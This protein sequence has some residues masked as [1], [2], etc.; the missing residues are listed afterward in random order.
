MT[1][2]RLATQGS[3]RSTV[4]ATRSEMALAW[5]SPPVRRGVFGS[6]LLLTGALSPAYLPEASPLRSLTGGLLGH[7]VVQTAA[8]SLMLV[9]VVILF[10]AWLR[11]RPVGGVT[12]PTSARATLAWWCLPLLV[13][14]PLFSSD[15]FSYAAQG[16]LVADGID[17]YQYGPFL[18]PD[19]FK[20]LVDPLW[21]Y[22]PAP[23]GPLS[24]QVNRFIVELTGRDAWWSAVLIRLPAILG[25]V[26]LLWAVRRLAETFGVDG[27][28]AIWWGVLNPI[29]LMHFV[30]GSHNDSLMV[31]IGAVALV[32]ATEGFLLGSA[33]VLGVAALMKQPIAFMLPACIALALAHRNGTPRPAFRQVVRGSLLAGG[34]FL[35]TFAAGT[36]ISGLGFG[37]ISAAGVPGSV[38][39]LSPS[40]NI[41]RILEWVLS[42]VHAPAGAL[43]M[44]MPLARTAV[45]AFGL[46]LGAFLALRCLH[47]ASR[48]AQYIC[49]GMIAV[50]SCLPALQ[51]W[52]LLWGG[53]FIG[54]VRLSERQERVVMIM[55]VALL[56]YSTID[57]VFRTGLLSFVI[58]AVMAMAFP[59]ITRRSTEHALPAFTPTVTRAWQA[60]VHRRSHHHSP[61]D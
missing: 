2:D 54:L 26:L 53:V 24:L 9:G 19:N 11:L 51:V 3:V 20:E 47:D 33:S 43:T 23:Y 17:P 14:P 38:G 58:L 40:T 35:G 37:W 5:S 7:W 29:V 49:W 13:A 61:H 15:S 46:G 12:P 57:A 16:R 55:M 59:R 52:Y 27:D 6:A 60:E 31:G 56:G 4:E 25:V 42:I 34:T 48:T 10:D 18:G 45:V 1:V 30:G 39:S 21:L 50:A 36:L 22:T 44:A 28:K 41:G 8:A 32:L